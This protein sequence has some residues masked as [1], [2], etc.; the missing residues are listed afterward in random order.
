MRRGA[1]W[2]RRAIARA[3]GGPAPGVATPSYQLIGPGPQI[4]LR[5]DPASISLDPGGP[6]RDREGSSENRRDPS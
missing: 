4:P 2:Q 3:A 1:I 6:E 5:L